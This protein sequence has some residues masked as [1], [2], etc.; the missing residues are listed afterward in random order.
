[1]ASPT[2]LSTRPPKA[3]D[4]GGQ[5]LEAAVDQVLHLLGVAG[6]G[7]RRE[8]DEVGEQ[9][10]DDPALVATDDAAAWPQDGQN[11]APR[12]RRRRTR[13]R[14][15]PS[16]TDTSADLP[17]TVDVPASAEGICPSTVVGGAGHDRRSTTADRRRPRRCDATKVYGIG[18]T[19]VRALDDV[20]VDVRRRAVHRHHGPV[21]L[22]Q[23]DADALRRRPRLA[24]L[25]ARSS[26]ATS[27]SARC[28][29]QAAHAAAPRPDRLRVPGVQPDPDAERHREHHAAARPRR[30]QAATR[31]GST[32]S[33]RH[34][35]PRR[36]ARA[37]ALAS[38]PAASSSAWRWP[39]P[40]PA[41]P[42]IIF[43]DE[44][45][46]NLDSRTAAEILAFMRR[47]VDELGQTIVMVTHDPRRRGV[48]RPG[49]CSSPT[50]HRRRD[51]RPDRRAGARPHEALRGLSAVRKVT[52]RSL[53]AHK[54]RLVSTVV[55][56]VLGVAFM[57]GT[58][59]F[60]DTIDKVFDDLFAADQRGR[61]RRGAGRGAVRR[62]LRRRRRSASCST[63]RS[64]THVAGV[65]GV[66]R[67]RAVRPDRRLRL[68]RTGCS[69][70]TATPSAPPTGRRR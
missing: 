47:A 59:V 46:G 36:P 52:L 10:G 13:R 50:A 28:R 25:A 37:P 9:H 69:T 51:G 53:W 1:M 40:W 21:G 18:D 33:C 49:R 45:T 41:G 20:T 58:F 38:C 30:P 57:S 31:R 54:R 65:D 68:A 24:H 61:R 16:R 4:V 8:A 12:R 26:S 29:R 3:G 39:G 62:R 32:R 22:G 2:I 7:Q 44:P 35:R 27:T 48:R 55:A 66:R 60:T 64:S 6:L 5:A 56:V 70:P 42:T 63:T 15:T 19:E 34:R 17:V 23:V 43:A 11:R 14:S 67:G